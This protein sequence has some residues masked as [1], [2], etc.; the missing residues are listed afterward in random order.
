M[1]DI[2]F[3]SIVILVIVAFIIG[4]VIGVS[5]TRPAVNQDWK[6][7]NKLPGDSTTDAPTPDNKKRPKGK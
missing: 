3:E 7:Q 6:E 2:S 5:L 4:M 1:M